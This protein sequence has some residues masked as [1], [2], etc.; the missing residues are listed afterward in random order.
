MTGVKTGGAILA[1]ALALSGCHSAINRWYL[2]RDLPALAARDVPRCEELDITGPDGRIYAELLRP[3]ATY[4]DRRPVVILFHG[5]PGFARFDGLGQ[6]LCRAGC[7][8]IVPYPPGSLEGTGKYTFGRSVDDATRLI[9]H[10]RSPAFRDEYGADG[11]AL[12]LIGH[13]LS[14]PQVMKAAALRR[15][16]VRG[17]MLLSP[18]D[19]GYSFGGMTEASVIDF[20]KTIG[21]DTL[22][23]DGLKAIY[24]E[25]VATS[26]SIS[27]A[28][29]AV[30]LKGMN[31]FLGTG[32]ADCFATTRP[33]D[34]FWS[35]PVFDGI[36]RQRKSYIADHSLLGARCALT[37]DV[38]DYIHFITADDKGLKFMTDEEIMLELYARIEKGES[39]EGMT[40]AAV[41]DGDG[42]EIARQGDSVSD[43]VSSHAHA[44]MNAIQAAEDEFGRH[45]LSRENL[46]LYVTSEPCAMCAGAMVQAGI[47]RVV[48]GVSAAEY[49]KVTARNVDL[50]TGWRQ[51]LESYGIAV[52]GPIEEAKGVTTLSRCRE[53]REKK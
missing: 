36:V 37:E 38:A 25:I 1:T 23:S 51:D 22:S 26:E 34:A 43:S 53:R 48:Y 19:I 10:V 7:V 35:A 21:A 11:R 5:Y 47:R 33:L 4:G 13:A 8:V 20:L 41:M 24:D 16:S 50:N 15:P 17:L 44:A 42:E 40:V 27:F 32:T 3:A 28:S 12:F 46:T 31:I 6:A 18:Y 14:C 49:A 30:P 52:T 2:N 29:L 9:D 39:A 45:E